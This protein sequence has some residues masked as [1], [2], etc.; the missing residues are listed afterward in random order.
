M[1]K[2]NKIVAFIFVITMVSL[3]LPNKNVQASVENVNIISETNITVDTAK[4][5]ASTKNATDTFKNLADLYWSLYK[6]H[7]NVNPAVAFVQ[8]AL[9]TGYGKFGGVIDESFNNPCGMKTTNTGDNS[10]PNAHQRFNSWNE[11]VQAHLDHLA[12]YAGAEG[13]P[14]S[15]T[16]DPRHFSAI[17]GTAT[18]VNEL[19]GKWATD[20]NYSKSIMSLYNELADYQAK[21]DN[22]DNSSFVIVVDPGHNKGGDNGASSTFDGITYS[23][24][25]LNMQIAKLLK[26]S[27]ENEGYTVIMTRNEGEDEYLGETESLNKRVQIANDANAD[28]FISIHQ[29][30]FEKPNAYGTEVYYSTYS[31]SGLTQE[32]INEKIAKSKE[33]A[34]KIVNNIC[35]VIGSTNRG[36]KTANF[37]VIKNTNMPAVLV[38]CGF[39]SNPDEAKRISDPS[40]QQKIADAITSAVK[41]VFPIDTSDIKPGDNQGS[42]EGGDNAGDNQGSTE[43]GDNT[44]DN[45]GSTEGG[46]STGDNQG[47]TE[48]GDSTGNNQGNSSGS[49][50]GTNTSDATNVFEMVILFMASGLII[51]NKKNN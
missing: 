40:N 37:Q 2:I 8:S 12:L 44:G 32:Q 3:L 22:K 23:E 31:T 36:D 49:Q 51:K 21:K 19:V 42:T 16:Y 48:G 30:S 39:I 20:P 24:T 10:D 11:G 9:E 45:Q 5:W 7:G 33:V 35:N 17:L 50:Q 29:N 38:E 25:E 43:G 18:T 6:E 14:R 15:N 34:S 27:L 41:S 4:E 46:D 26:S 47:S 1:K 13:Y 28:L